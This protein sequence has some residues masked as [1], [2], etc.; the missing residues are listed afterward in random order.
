MGNAST[1]THEFVCGHTDRASV[2]ASLLPDR[3]SRPTADMVEALLFLQGHTVRIQELAAEEASLQKPESQPLVLLAAGYCGLLGS[4]NE[5][6]A[7]EEYL[8]AFR[9]KVQNGD[10]FLQELLVLKAQ[11]LPMDKILTL[12]P[13]AEASER[14]AQSSRCNNGEVFR[15][16]AAFLRGCV[17]CG[18]IYAEIRECGA[19]GQLDEKEVALWLESAESDQKRMINAMGRCHLEGESNSPR[20]PIV[21]AAGISHATTF[22]ALV[23]SS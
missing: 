8:S 20:T 21:G 23:A 1:R 7:P 4:S 22:A 13:L 9:S 3:L 16:L 5:A 10:E 6:K 19:S 18:E 17:E 2:A 14:S 11:L 15:Q 12:K